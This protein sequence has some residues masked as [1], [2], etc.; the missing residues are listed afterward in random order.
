MGMA[1]SGTERS[2]VALAA[3][4]AQEAGE[5]LL[6]VRDR[7]GSHDPY[8]LGA[9]GDRHANTLIL[10]R[11]RTARP[12]DAILSHD[13][14]EGCHARAGLVS[15]LMVIENHPARYL[16][17]VNRRH[18]WMRGDWQLLPWLMRRVPGAAMASGVCMARPD[19]CAS[20]WRTVDPGGPAGVSSSTTPSSTATWTAR[21][22][23]GL[24]TEAR[25]NTRRVSPW[26]ASTPAG[27][28]T[29]AAA[30]LTGQ[31]AMAASARDAAITSWRCSSC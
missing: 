28:T 24:V 26:A 1:D 5:F 10:D 6:S 30:A 8:T 29:A 20:R 13:L 27:P 4:V 23:S 7:L 16:A 14:I 18:R 11:L 12:D 31:S 22:T 15:D 3:E 17:D 2:D 25:A 21:A 19:V 9:A